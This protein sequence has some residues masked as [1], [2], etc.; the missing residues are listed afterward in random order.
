LAGAIVVRR[1]ARGVLVSL[2]AGSGGIAHHMCFGGGVTGQRGWDVVQGLVRWHATDRPARIRIAD[3]NC[4]DDT[5]PGR[6]V[7][8]HT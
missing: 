8:G 3:V 4:P 7:I 1:E 2:A 5:G 6:Q